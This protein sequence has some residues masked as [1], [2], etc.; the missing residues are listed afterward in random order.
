[1]ANRPRPRLPRRTSG[2]RTIRTARI[3]I[4]LE[5]D[6]P[7]VWNNSLA[8]QF[9]LDGLPESGITGAVSGNVVTLKLKETSPAKSITYLKEM[10]W[11][12]DKLLVG[13]NGIAALTFCDVPLEPARPNP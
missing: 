6:Q 4:A 9:Y 5:F 13:V 2:E 1:M 12:Q 11:N 8:S 10:N 7:V 3:A